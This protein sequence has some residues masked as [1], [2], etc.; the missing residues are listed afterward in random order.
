MVRT[1]GSKIQQT[2]KYRVHDQDMPEPKP[3]PKV[4]GAKFQN[5]GTLKFVTGPVKEAGL[6]GYCRW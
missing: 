1:E 5:L 4:M 3:V 2:K 6:R